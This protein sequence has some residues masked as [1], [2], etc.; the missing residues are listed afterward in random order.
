MTCYNIDA[1][2]GHL[3]WS[4][5]RD[6]IRPE[7]RIRTRWA[8]AAQVAAP[9]AVGRTFLHRLQVWPPPRRGRNFRAN[10]AGCLRALDVLHNSN[11]VHGTVADAIDVIPRRQPAHGRFRGIRTVWRTEFSRWTNCREVTRAGAVPTDMARTVQ[12][13]AVPH[14][15]DAGKSTASRTN[16]ERRI[17]PCR[18]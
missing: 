12:A 7:S 18:T 14:G 9:K 13:E 11:R 1:G 6:G 3:V 2:Q 17:L 4:E 15:R 10:A 8:G 5:Q 16:H